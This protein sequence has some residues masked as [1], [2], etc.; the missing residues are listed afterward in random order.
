[1]IGPVAARSTVEWFESKRGRE[2]LKRLMALGVAPIEG[3]AKAKDSPFAGKTVVL[4]GTLGKMSRSEA[5]EIVRA[6]GGNI[7]GSVSSKTD[8]VIAGLNAGT[9][10]DDANRL[11]VKIINEIEFFA[12]LGEDTVPKSGTK[13]SSQLDFQLS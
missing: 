2:T 11:G 4:T 12:M 13:K 1:V 5:Q 9:K 6:L 10:L 7:S 8:F 3:G